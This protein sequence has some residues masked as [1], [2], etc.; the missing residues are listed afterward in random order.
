[1]VNSIPFFYHRKASMDSDTL[2]MV[3][4]KGVVARSRR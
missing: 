2:D 1:M 4:H 3:F